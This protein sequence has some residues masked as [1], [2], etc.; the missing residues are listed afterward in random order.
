MNKK[1][2]LIASLCVFVSLHGTEQQGLL[3]ENEAND[4]TEIAISSDELEE[5]ATE[6]NKSEHEQ[7]SLISEI[8]NKQ[9]AAEKCEWCSYL[10]CACSPFSCLAAIVA[11]I[12]V[13]PCMCCIG[14]YVKALCYEEVN[15]NLPCIECCATR[16]NDHCLAACNRGIW[17]IGCVCCNVLCESMP[18]CCI[19][20]VCCCGATKRG[21]QSL[22][23]VFGNELARRYALRA[24]NP[25]RDNLLVP[26]QII[27]MA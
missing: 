10:S 16:A 17:C 24:A 6:H 3:P 20:R 5:K 25:E 14:C 23:K 2:W 18:C 22:Q 8:P 1:M 21:Y 27:E 12:G 4:F 15:S 26:K 7:L 9:E 19:E 11:G 13:C